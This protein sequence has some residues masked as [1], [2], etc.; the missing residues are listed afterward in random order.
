MVKSGRLLATAQRIGSLNGKMLRTNSNGSIQADNPFYG[1]AVGK[2]RAIWGRS[3]RNPYSF[4]V[5][6]GTGSILIND[7]GQSAYEINTGRSGANY[8]WP[9]HEGPEDDPR[10]DGPLRYYGHGSSATRGCAI[11]GGAFYDPARV[12]FPTEYVGDYFFADFCSGWIR[13]FDPE[14]NTTLSTFKAG[15]G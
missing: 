14:Q 7:V 11:T 15:S 12:T 9:V 5:Q 2:N 1:T 13:R 10:Y 8:G 6:P 3:L 4:A